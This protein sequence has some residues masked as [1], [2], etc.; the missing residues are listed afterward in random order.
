MKRSAMLS[1][2]VFGLA[3][4]LMLVV[5]TDGAMAG[6]VLKIATLAPE[7]SAWMNIFDEINAEII[8]KTDKRVRFRVYAGGVMGDESDVMRKMFVGQVHGSVIT[9]S[10]LTRIL[11]DMDV[12]QVPFLF[13]NYEEVDYLLSKMDAHFRTG[14]E[15]NGYVMLG[16]SEGGFVRLMSTVPIVTLDD[17][18]KAKVWVWEE[19][20]MTLA[21]FKEA[22]VSGIP[23]SMPDVLVGLQTGLVDVVYAPPAGAISLQWFTKTKYIT[24]V[25]LMY[26]TGIIVVTKKAFDRLSADDQAIVRETFDR[27]QERMRTT[28]RS[29]NRSALQ[30]MTDS[31]IQLLQVSK[32]QIEQYKVVADRAVKQPGSTSFAPETLHQVEAHLKAFRQEKP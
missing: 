8:R 24:D 10:S 1:L 21:I 32:D 2:A 31:G 29:E 27:Q 5:S 18:R 6:N 15:K 17:L 20:P 30:V 16:W 23:L 3:A 14:L 22:G 9:A 11:P 4:A 26:V 25:P 19:A 7:G 13:Q 12:L 28:V